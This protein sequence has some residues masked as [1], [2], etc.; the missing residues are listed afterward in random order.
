MIFV[1]APVFAAALFWHHDPQAVSVHRTRLGAWTLV[2][3]VD[4]FIKSVN[5]KLYAQGISYENGVVAFQFSRSARTYDAVYSLDGAAPVSWRINA[6][7][8]ARLGAAFSSN[9]VE[10]PSGGQVS[11]PYSV[12]SSSVTLTIR[13]D[14]NGGTRTI[15]LDPLHAARRAAS[16]MGCL[17]SFADGLEP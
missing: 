4:P 8:L 1:M 7:E 13:P 17:R 2:R 6:L 16:G 3:T 12:L 10:N 5:C 14:A 11:I 15:R 9:D